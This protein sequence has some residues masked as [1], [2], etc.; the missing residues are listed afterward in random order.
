VHHLFE[1]I[2]TLGALYVLIFAKLREFIVKLLIPS[3]KKVT[4]RV[5]NL[6]VPF[7]VHVSVKV[8]HT[9]EH[10]WSPVLTVLTM[11]D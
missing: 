9:K 4:F 8:S 1:Y 2:A 11:E 3:L 6:R 10:V 5:E 7:R